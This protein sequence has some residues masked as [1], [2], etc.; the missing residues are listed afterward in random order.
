MAERKSGWAQPA[1]LVRRATLANDPEFIAVVKQVIDANG[2]KAG[3]NYIVDRPLDISKVTYKITDQAEAR[4]RYT[5]W[6]IKQINITTNPLQEKMTFFWHGI[7]TSDHNAAGNKLRPLLAIQ[8]NMMR[9]KALTNYRDLLH[10]FVK[11]GLLCRYLN[12]NTNKADRINENLARELM[13]LFTTGPGHYSETDIREAAKAMSGWVVTDNLEVLYRPSRGF[14]D[15]VK[16]LGETK[17]WDL[18]SITDRLLD[19]PATADRISAKLWYELVGNNKPPADLGS[20][21]LAQN[22]DIKWLLKRILNDSAFKNGNHYV[23][24]RTGFEYL[25]N[26][27]RALGQVPNTTQ[28]INLGQAPWHPPDVAGWQ[29]GNRWFDLGSLLARSKLI[30]L[31]YAEVPNGR[32]ASVEMVLDRCSIF[33]VSESTLQILNSLKVGA[34]INENGLAQ[35]RWR[36]ALSSPEAN[37]L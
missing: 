7:L 23:R 22:Y 5:N 20:G 30:N 15:N 14:N 13:E 31:N 29:T 27:K 6:Y 8:I 10:A 4:R 36:I 16:F 19:H 26:T 11:D 3:V 21:W 33:E 1:K 9:E 32:N 34:G 37:L 28:G 35:L 12:A 25:V 2:W 18:E 24:P 17:K